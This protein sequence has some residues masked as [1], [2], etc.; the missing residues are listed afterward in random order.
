MNVTIE[1]GVTGRIIATH[2][3]PFGEAPHAHVWDVEVYFH[4]AFDAL[5]VDSRI[6]QANL[7]RATAELGFDLSVK[8]GERATNEGIACWLL[9]RLHL[10]GAIKVG[11]R[12]PWE[13]SFAI[14]S[15]A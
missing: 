13:R 1:S 8:L 4:H 15:I 7:D 10:D 2:C 11:V 3:E 14:A 5:P 9:S 6:R 12:R